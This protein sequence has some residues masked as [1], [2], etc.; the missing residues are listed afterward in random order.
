AIVAH[1]AVAV[2]AVAVPVV[3]AELDCDFGNFSLVVLDD[4][5][6]VVALS[7]FV[8]SSDEIGIRHMT[9][10]GLVLVIER[11]ALDLVP[12]GMYPLNGISDAFGERNRGVPVQRGAGEGGVDDVS[13]VL[14]R[15]L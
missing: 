12:V 15:P 1:A 9:V 13:R 11:L 6:N 4:T 7:C 2:A 5:L 8:D 10:L 14:P 3:G